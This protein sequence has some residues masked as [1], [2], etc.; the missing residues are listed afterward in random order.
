MLHI[1]ISDLTGNGLY[2][3]ARILEKS[4]CTLK[5]LDTDHILEGL[6]GLILNIF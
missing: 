4:L 5:S 1:L 6:T 3:L 2:A